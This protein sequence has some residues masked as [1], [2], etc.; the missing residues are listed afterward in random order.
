MNS[1]NK[2]SGLD[3]RLERLLSGIELAALRKRMRRYF[4]RVDNGASG[5][6]LRLTQL[7]DTEPR[8]WLFSPVAHHAYRDQRRLTFGNWMLPCLRLESQVR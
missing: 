7:S 4:E 2:P 8:L 1:T 6:I 5:N 3:D